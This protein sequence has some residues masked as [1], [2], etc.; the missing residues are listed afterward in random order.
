MQ[1]AQSRLG[2]GLGLAHCDAVGP[3]PV[4]DA[5]EVKGH[6]G[7]HDPAAVEKDAAEQHQLARNWPDGGALHQLGSGR[8]RHG[9]DGDL[10][11]V[12]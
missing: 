11:I 8:H 12:S 9:V 5:I 6:T 3:L 4:F 7:E 1:V 2:R 10:A